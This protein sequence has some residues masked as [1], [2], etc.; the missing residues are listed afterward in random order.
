MSR[1]AAI[2]RMAWRPIDDL[3][4]NGASRL[5]KSGNDLALGRWNGERWVYPA[6]PDFPVDFEPLEYRP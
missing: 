1:A 4:R 2:A 5:V 6:T 3:A